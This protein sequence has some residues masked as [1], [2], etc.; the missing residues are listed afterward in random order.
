MGNFLTGKGEVQT[1]QMNW[2]HT[3]DV[4]NVNR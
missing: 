1:L 3:D 4:M 2:L